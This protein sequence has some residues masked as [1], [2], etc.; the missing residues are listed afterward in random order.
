MALRWEEFFLLKKDY[1]EQQIEKIYPSFLELLFRINVDSKI[2]YKIHNMFLVLVYF[3][4]SNIL[5]DEE[6]KKHLRYISNF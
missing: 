6:Y 2:L 1:Y 4:I 3:P 5:L